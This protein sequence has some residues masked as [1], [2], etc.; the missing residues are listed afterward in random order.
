MKGFQQKRKLRNILESWP[1]LIFLGALLLF[2]IWGVLSFMVKMRTTIENRRIAEHKIEELEKAKEKLSTDIQSLNTEEGKERVF[3]ENF[4]LAKE[5][6]GLIVVVDDKN[7][8]AAEGA[9]KEGFFSFFKNW[10]K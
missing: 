1:V 3:R 7:A 6:E 5:G 9:N 10:F 8:A 2:F 4:G